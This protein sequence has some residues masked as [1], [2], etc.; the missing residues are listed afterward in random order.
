MLLDEVLESEL[1]GLKAKNLYRSL[2]MV[3]SA[4]GP[5]IKVEGKDT[6]LFCSN[7]YLGL[8]N[9]PRLIKAAQDALKKYGTSSGASRLISGTMSLHQKLEEEVAI[10]K[11]QEA[12]L[13]FSSGYMANL[14]T[15]AALIGLKDAVISDRLN[16]AS[17]IDGCRLSRAELKIYPHNN[18][19][20]LEA[21]LKKCGN[22]RRRLI[23]TEGIFSMD[24]DIAPLPKICK[25]A[26]KYD[27]WL[28]VDDAHATGVLGK[29]GKGSAEYFKLKP[30]DVDIYMGT[31]SKALGSMG[32]FITGSKKLIDYLKNKARTFIY[33]TSLPPAV[34]AASSE[35][36][37]IVKD[38]RQLREKLWGNVKYFKNRLE[39]LGYDT[40]NSQTQIIPLLIKDNLK[41]MELSKYLFEQGLF[42]VGIRPPSV[43]PNTSRIRLSVMATHTK[44]D[45]DETLSILKEAGER[46]KII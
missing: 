41:T 21:I 44:K 20:A 33:S 14:G 27:A 43:P 26:K 34:L 7:N 9:H 38:E 24:G 46:L 18:I 6:L 23:I 45:M 2:R 40:M 3:S 19:S 32:G 36:L 30:N 22:F 1:E 13:V 31:F 16:H 42:A 11:E 10:F 4:Q 12:G 39:N 28:M 8:A 5:R 37:K 15:I 35:A 25:L 29:N 17:L